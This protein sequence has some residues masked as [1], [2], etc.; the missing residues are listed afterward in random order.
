M[1][2]RPTELND[3]STWCIYYLSAA[4]AGG[5]GWLSY[6]GTAYNLSPIA[7]KAIDLF[8]CGW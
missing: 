8:A 4:L 3:V 6:D 2:N 5:D 7:N 1:I